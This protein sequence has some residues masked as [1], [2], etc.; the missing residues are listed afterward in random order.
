MKDV[1]Y[2]DLDDT[3]VFSE[4]RPDGSISVDVRSGAVDF[5][6]ALSTYG[7]VWILSLGNRAHVTYSLRKLGRAAQRVVSGI[8]PSEDLEP[9]I[10]QI[11]F[12]DASPGLRSSDRL[13]LE[14][15]IPQIAPSGA[16]FDDQPVG[17]PRYRIKRAAVGI[18]PHLWIQVPDTPEGLWNAYRRFLGR[19]VGKKGKRM[20]R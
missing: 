5:L 14:Q 4:V 13:T 20:A 9:V 15:E 8:I 2:S 11:E 16:V 19:L 3:L 1:L 12:I 17:S 7:D 10:E 6:K 18:S